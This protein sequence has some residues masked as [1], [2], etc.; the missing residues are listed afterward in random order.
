MYRLSTTTS[1]SDSRND[2]ERTRGKDQEEHI[3]D[4]T[5]SGHNAAQLKEQDVPFSTFLQ[6]HIQWTLHNF[7]GNNP[8]APADDDDDIGADE[9]MTARVHKDVSEST[10]NRDVDDSQNDNFERKPEDT[11]KQERPFSGSEEEKEESFSEF[12]KKHVKKQMGDYLGTGA[13]APVDI[14]DD[15][16]DS[17]RKSESTKERPSFGDS[18]EETQESFSEFF[19][20]H[21]EKRMKDYLGP[22]V[23]RQENEL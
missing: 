23:P 10:Q 3:N 6:N 15:Y 4:Q 1:L 11:K 9:T 14:R 12:F 5:P 2:D 19:K 7:F 22:V 20:K 8:F 17:E 21:V 13:V 16:S 18:K